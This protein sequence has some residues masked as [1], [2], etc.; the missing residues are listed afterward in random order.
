[1]AANKS[2]GQ[3]LRPPAGSP[4]AYARQKYGYGHQPDSPFTIFDKQSAE[5]ALHLI[6]HADTSAEKTW[7]K[8]QAAKLGVRP[9]GADG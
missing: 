5:A 9:K 4:T 6:G 2:G 7:I 1:M 3:A 8:S